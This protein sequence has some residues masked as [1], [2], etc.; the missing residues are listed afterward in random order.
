MLVLLR[1]WRCRED[2]LQ[3]KTSWQAAFNETT[4]DRASKRLLRN[5][6]VLYEC[7]DARDDYGQQR[8]SGRAAP[9]N[10]V[11]EGLE[12]I[13]GLCEMLG[14]RNPAAMQD[15]C[16]ALYTRERMRQVRM[17]EPLPV[18]DMDE[19]EPPAIT[20][21]GIS[22]DTRK[23][24]VKAAVKLR[25]MEMSI[26]AQESMRHYVRPIEEGVRELTYNTATATAS[27]HDLDEFLRSK[28]EQVAKRFGLNGDQLRAY[29]LITNG[30]MGNR[31]LKPLRMYLAGVGGTGKSQVM[32]A[33]VQFFNETGRGKKIAVLAPTGTAASL[34]GGQTYHSFLGLNGK[35]T[36][37]EKG[38][39][40]E[41][42][43][44]RMNRIR[45]TEVLIIDEVSM[46]GCNELYNIA[47]K[48]AQVKERGN[49]AFGGAHM[50]FAGDFAQL[51]PVQSKPLYGRVD[52]SIKS[53]PN[54]RVVIGR[55]LWE[56]VTTV[57]V[58]RKNQRQ[59]ETGSK[60]EKLRTLL[61]NARMRD[62]TDDDI[63]FMKT[64]IAG[65]AG[66][67]QPLPD[68]MTRTNSV[69]TSTN[70]ER[71]AINAASARLYAS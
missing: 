14:Q 9:P 5:F 49:E 50:V 47:S 17:L 10:N 18:M 41:Q 4:F 60:D 25:Q 35:E 31:Q 46:I 8:R 65:G 69:I 22:T 48:L 42:G 39:V 51:P 68:I 57:V 16:N 62:C 38:I 6:N 67:T 53:E 54:Q 36:Q 34:I 2:L 55:S 56:L 11:E 27:T 58:L 64:L 33:V 21:T 30:T 71:D 45:E 15:D 1:P 52:A 43:A 29:D 70:A 44:E 3:G 20:Q 28:A 13:G 61:T 23:S 32:K 66:G 7:L 12:D 40:T 37:S 24:E 19:N 26:Q 59:T 63:D